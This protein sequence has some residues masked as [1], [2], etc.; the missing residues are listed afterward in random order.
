[1]SSQTYLTNEAWCSLSGFLGVAHC[2]GHVPKVKIIP[3]ANLT[4]GDQV[5]LCFCTQHIFKSISLQFV[6]IEIV[7]NK[8]SSTGHATSRLNKDVQDKEQEGTGED[9]VD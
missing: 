6:I 4:S 5:L 9:Q 7:G 8:T 1:M 2:F 3:N